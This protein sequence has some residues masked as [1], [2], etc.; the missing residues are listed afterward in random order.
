MNGGEVGSERH[1]AWAVQAIV[2]REDCDN[3][4]QPGNVTECS[5][6]SLLI[7]AICPV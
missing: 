7:T 6:A 4:K 5:L 1:V 2:P 3:V